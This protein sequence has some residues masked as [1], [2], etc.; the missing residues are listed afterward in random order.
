MKKALGLFLLLALMPSIGGSQTSD[1]GALPLSDDQ[2][3]EIIANERAKHKDM[4]APYP[5]YD[6]SIRR[7]GCYYI[8]IENKLV[9]SALPT[10]RLYVVDA[11]RIFKLNKHGAIVDIPTSTRR[12]MATEDQKTP[13]WCSEEKVFSE[14]ELAEIVAKA[15]EKR[16][17]LPQPFPKC[18]VQV[19]RMG[20]VYYYQEFALAETQGNYQVF[21]IDK[22][23]EL[24]NVHRPHP[25]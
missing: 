24:M 11:S 14:K 4:P 12:T 13:S 22:F 19:I 9:A 3:K 25:Y 21:L 10:Q 1:C 16:S 2:I 18:R 20:C 6:T 15:R 17:D 8:Y 23:G 5:Q 7:D